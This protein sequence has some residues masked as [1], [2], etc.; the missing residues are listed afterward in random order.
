MPIFFIFWLF[1][2][3]LD[4]AEFGVGF[5]WTPYIADYR[6][7]TRIKQESEA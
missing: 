3:W 4:G 6:T 2:Q 1:F 5:G 7:S